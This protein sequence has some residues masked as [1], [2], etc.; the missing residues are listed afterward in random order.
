MNEDAPHLFNENV[1]LL[2]EIL[3]FNKQLLKDNSS[4]LDHNNNYRIAWGYLRLSGL[5][6]NYIGASKVQLYKYKFHPSE[7]VVQQL[8][9]QY[10]RVPFVYYD[11]IYP[12]KVKLVFFCLRSDRL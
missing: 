6:K 10:R 2:F 11:F 8:K 4:L 9:T 3:D 7:S 12:H 5:A 1:V